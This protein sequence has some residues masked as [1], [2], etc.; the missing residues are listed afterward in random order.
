MNM[1][2]DVAAQGLTRALAEMTEQ[3]GR[4]EAGVI[5]NAVRLPAA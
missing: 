1:I 3:G 2:T 4:Q 5:G